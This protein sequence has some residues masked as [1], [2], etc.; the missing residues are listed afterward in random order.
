[1]T[2]TAGIGLSPQG[3][4]QTAN[5][6]SLEG[7]PQYGV[8]LS[9]TPDDPVVENHSG[10]MVIGYDIQSAEINGRPMLSINQILAPSML[11]AGIP[12]G[13]SVY[14]MGNS[15]VSLQRAGRVRTMSP[16]RGPAVRATLRAA[17][18]CGRA[19]CGAG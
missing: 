19:V 4:P 8:T 15:P 10:R 5:G 2:Q 16:G 12:G 1:V 9:G 6:Y 13:E 18:F 11:P 14:A 3:A 17:V 7:L